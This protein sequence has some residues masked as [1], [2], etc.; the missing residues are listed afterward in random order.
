MADNAQVRV[1]DIRDQG[2]DLSFL[3]KMDRHTAHR[4]GLVDRVVVIDNT[5][6]LLDNHL[7][8]LRL[9]S[10]S[11][12]RAVICVAVGPI[13]ENAGIELRQSAALGQAGVT[14]WVGDEWGSR[15]AGGTDRPRPITDGPPTMPDLVAALADKQI[16]DAVFDTVRLVPYQT[17]CPGLDVVHPAVDAGDLRL[18]RAQAL[19]DLVRHN[20]TS[21]PT[22]PVPAAPRQRDTLDPSR[23]RIRADSPLGQS[24]QTLRRA[25]DQ[26]TSTSMSTSTLRAL[27]TGGSDVDTSTLLRAFEN[28]TDQV[29]T[30]LTLLDREAGGQDVTDQ[31]SALGVPPVDP[32]DN[33]ALAA[34]LRALLLNELREGRSLLDLSALLR[35]VSNQ[36]MPEGSAQARMELS[37][38]GGV[39]AGLRTPF[40]PGVW[41]LPAVA[42][43]ALAAI[44]TTAATWITSSAVAGTIAGLLWAALIALFVLRW[45]GRKASPPSGTD[46][47]AVVG[48]VAAGA[49][50]VAAGMVLPAADVPAPVALVVAVA[51]GGLAVVSVAIAWRAVVGKWGRD[52]ADSGIRQVVRRIESVVDTRVQ[53]HI[54]SLQH[55][56]RLSDAALLLASGLAELARVYAANVTQDTAPERTPQSQAAAELLAVMHGDLVSLTMRAL[57]SYLIMI[58]AGSPLATDKDALVAN[59]KQDLAEYHRYMDTHGIHGAPPMVDENSARETLALRLWQKSEPG[60][61]VL[62]GDGREELVQLCQTG[63]VRALNVAWK[64]VHVLR[65]APP[66]VQRIV[67][68]GA[69]APDIIPA[70]VDMVG[71]LRLVPLGTG[72]VVH[73]QP[74]YTDP[75]PT[76]DGH[77]D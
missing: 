39:P 61:R 4:L 3:D 44:A 70:D 10:L 14:L 28:H 66:A 40:R 35:R 1:L 53:D 74:T 27:F 30:M 57:D 56:R 51:A 33:S 73:E 47:A 64:N 60:R 62:R 65:F 72:R 49:V 54:R 71:L 9:V 38:N 68:G 69:A 32:S 26:L 43:L 37:G 7:R 18:L 12:V 52:L 58:G 67:L 41:P 20:T 17:A 76:L 29:G 25:V 45:P 15:W 22:P 21:S 59:A 48:G 11:H 75:D 63:D 55:K 24:R 46:W 19:D 50:G 16:F 34:D 31:L 13:D 77:G 5:H 6:S 36:N 2:P 8:F 42:L 23:D